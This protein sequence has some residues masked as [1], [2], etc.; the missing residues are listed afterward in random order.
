MRIA[1]LSLSL[2]FYFFAQSQSYTYYLTGDTTDVSPATMPGICLMGGASEHDNAMIWF[3]ERANGGNVLVIRA[4]GSDGYNDYLYSDL[5]V[6]LQSVETIVF[7]NS[8]AAE[9]PFVLDRI[10]KAEAIW[11]AGGD[12]WDYVSY[13]RNSSV[14]TLLNTHILIKQSP[15]GGTS[16]GMAILGGTYFSAENGTITSSTALNNPFANSLTLGYEDF[17]HAPYLQH[18]VTDTHYDDPDR[19]GRHITFL[20]RMAA[21]Q[22]VIARGIACDEYTSVC[23]DEN[24]IARVFGEYPTYDDFA[25]FLQ[26]NCE[27]PID[28][29]I[30]QEGSP[31]TWDRND[32]AVKV[33]FVQ[34]DWEGTK[35]LDLN[36]WTT[37]SGG[38]WQNWWV[39]SGSLTELE[40]EEPECATNLNEESELD[41]FQL[42]EFSRPLNYIGVLEP[43][44][45]VEVIDCRGVIIARSSGQ[46]VDMS[47]AALGIYQVIV[48]DSDGQSGTVQ[49]V[50]R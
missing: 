34:G 46:G 40:N 27:G 18:T 11:I 32:A 1:V 5:G 31:L 17:L 38:I 41:I 12:Q 8:S 19:K 14:G 50:K 22:G 43:D 25:Y 28:P 29:E 42:I 9:D 15:I 6:T 4:S 20:A 49:V 44:I 3:L 24:G 48:T 45:T 26:A 10:S 39:E 13:W 37:G 16:A 33:Y 35:H 23:I 7:D 36:D 30:C 47:Q 21:D 2:L